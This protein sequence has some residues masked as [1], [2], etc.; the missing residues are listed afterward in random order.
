MTR[1]GQAASV[2]RQEIHILAVR[3]K[4]EQTSAT[5]TLR[6][7]QRLSVLV[8]GAEGNIWTQEG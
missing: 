2:G 5:L 7:E 3:R 1:L 4:R 6:E 8:Q